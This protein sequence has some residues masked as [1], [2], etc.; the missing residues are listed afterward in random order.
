MRAS[1]GIER[2]LLIGS[3]LALVAAGLYGAGSVVAKKAMGDYDIP[4]VVFT[5]FSLLLGTLMV[6]ALAQGNIRSDLRVPKRY[7][8][9]VMAAGVA[10]GLGVT[11]LTL[12]VNRAPVAV[13]TP[14]AA[15][16]PI[17]TLILVHLFLQRLERISPRVVMGTLVAVIG[18]ILVI[19]GSSQ[20]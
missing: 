15:L 2:S 8:G 7:L 5:S 20:L 1:L 11:F 19:V 17:V 13:V 16:N 14:I 18:V 10:S 9:F 6:F 12:A 3:G 4:P